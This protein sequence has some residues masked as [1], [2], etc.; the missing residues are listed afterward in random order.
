[1]FGNRHRPAASPTVVVAI[2]EESYRAAP[3]KGSPT[4]TW[5]GEIGRVLNAV[6]EGGAKV[7]GFDMVIPTSI[8]QSEIP[9]REGMRGERF[10]GFDGVFWRAR[11]G[12]APPGKIVLGEQRR[13]NEPIRPSPGQRI[14]VR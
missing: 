1:M 5:T 3:F 12:A 9:F 7:V 8:E 14:A 13:G 6:M 4:L 2:D 10:R 11:A